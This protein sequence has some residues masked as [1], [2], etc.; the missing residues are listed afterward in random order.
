MSKVKGLQKQV[1]EYAEEEVE[2]FI[3]TIV[4]SGWLDTLDVNWGDVDPDDVGIEAHKYMISIMA[5]AIK[6]L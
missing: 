2:N 5:A 3:N 1:K 4:D 6:K